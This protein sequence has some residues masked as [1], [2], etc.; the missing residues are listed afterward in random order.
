MTT[1]LYPYELAHL[2]Q[3]VHEERCGSRAEC[4]CGWAGPWTDDQVA[5][6]YVA[7]HR[8]VAVGP[9]TG[10][11]AALSG[12]L[13]LQDD[14]A[15]AVMWLAENWSADLPTPRATPDCHYRPNG[16]DVP[17]VRMLVYCSARDE[18]VRLAGLLD[19]PLGVESEPN[20]TGA[21][22]ERAIRRFG[23][24]KLEVYRE[25]DRQGG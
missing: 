7:D 21:R 1:V 22:Y 20:S 8:E 14:L 19:I 6:D 18:L 25:F 17:G 2:V 12:L 11:D 9:R 16:D 13:D 4:S 15:D 3:V 5:A 24:V 23:R 10:L